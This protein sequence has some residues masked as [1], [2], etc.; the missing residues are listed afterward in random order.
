MWFFPL[1]FML[2]VVIFII[3]MIRGGMSGGPMCGGSHKSPRSGETPREALDRRYA[4]GEITR[5]QYQQIRN[6]LE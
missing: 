1:F 3:F 4:L 6:D 5:E 2:L